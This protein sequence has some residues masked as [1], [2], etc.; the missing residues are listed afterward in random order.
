MMQ[1]LKFVKMRVSIR[2][3]QCE[4]Y[5]VHF[6]QRICWSIKDFI[7]DL[8]RKFHLPQTN[9]YWL[10]KD[11]DI[12][13]ES[14]DEIWNMGRYRLAKF[15]EIEN[16]K[17]QEFKIIFEALKIK[18]KLTSNLI[19]KSAI[20]NQIYNDFGDV[21]N[22]FKSL[23]IF[24]KNGYIVNSKNTTTLKKFDK[25]ID[26]KVNILVNSKDKCNSKRIELRKPRKMKEKV[27]SHCINNMAYLAT[28]DFEDFESQIIHCKER[29]ELS[30]TIKILGL[31][32]GFKIIVPN[33]NREGIRTT[34]QWHKT[35]FRYNVSSTKR[36]NC[37]FEIIYEKVP[38]QDNYFLYKY[39]H[40]HNHPLEEYDV[41]LGESLLNRVKFIVSEINKRKNDPKL[42]EKLSK[43]ENFRIDSKEEAN[44]LD[45]EQE[46][47]DLKNGQIDVEDTGI[48]RPWNFSATNMKIFQID[49]VCKSL[50][51]WDI[52][53][54]DVESP[55]IE[56]RP[57]STHMT[58]VYLNTRDYTQK[59]DSFKRPR[60]KIL[61]YAKEVEL[62]L[63][64]CYYNEESDLDNFIRKQDSLESTK[65]LLESF[66]NN[67][68]P[69]D[70]NFPEDVKDKYN[71]L[72]Q[73]SEKISPYRIY[74][75]PEDWDE[76]I[77][78]DP[79]QL[80]QIIFPKYE[81]FSTEECYKKP[82]I[83]IE[84]K[85]GIKQEEI[86]QE[87]SSSETDDLQYKSIESY[88]S[89]IEVEFSDESEN[90]ESVQS[91]KPIDIDIEIRDEIDNDIKGIEANITWKSELYVTETG[92]GNKKRNKKIQHK[93]DEFPN[94]NENTINNDL[95]SHKI[96]KTCE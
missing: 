13:L 7:L 34:Y 49:A 91:I 73:M 6:D 65:N 61:E 84:S 22:Y 93:I 9:E 52:K 48:M 75:V 39:R 38:G 43:I 96:Q 77:D 30:Q 32:K 63:I 45:F 14:I 86:Q 54:G 36:T 83:K 66:T 59:G 37:P 16:I 68:L 78:K 92:E 88:I 58:N 67:E 4:R 71:K 18:K 42:L 76:F 53:K 5:L 89:N 47:E 8:L 85:L 64:G 72:I 60:L 95:N 87:S 40:Y 57:S 51:L 25:N 20:F 27:S 19:W 33:G 82:W 41:F 50:A 81:S 56:G 3:S 35:G 23:G 17:K 15:S 46:I 70:A 69:E 94:K 28:P 62:E 29:R 44:D 55:E 31:L 80:L 24:A 21:E 11:P 10:L 26:K 1:Y 2:I 79:L 90:D 74:E 12:I